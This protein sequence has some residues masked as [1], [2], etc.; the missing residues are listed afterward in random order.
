VTIEWKAR[1]KTADIPWVAVV[2]P[3]GDV[4]RRREVV[5]SVA[6]ERTETMTSRLHDARLPHR[7][8]RL[9]ISK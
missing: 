7:A 9:V 2:I 6:P 8:P 3:N 1:P 4:S 5:A